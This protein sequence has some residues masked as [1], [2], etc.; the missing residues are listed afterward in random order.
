[1]S[2]DSVPA[3]TRHDLWAE[4][5]HFTGE[6][7]PF[8]DRFP[9]LPA[10]ELRALADD[11]K[12]NGLR[13]PLLLTPDGALVD[14]RNR[15]AACAMA[16]VTP[17]FE[18]TEADPYVVIVSAN[19]E[20]RHLKRYQ[21]AMARALALADQGK[22]RN[23]RWEYGTNAEESSGFVRE[24]QRCGVVIDYRPDLAQAILSDDKQ[25][26]DDAYQKAKTAKTRTE[27]LAEHDPDLLARVGDDLDLDTAWKQYQAAKARAEE[28]REAKERTYREYRESIHLTASVVE[29]L[30]HDDNWSEFIAHYQPG[31]FVTLTSER[32]RRI[33]ELA[34]EFADRWD[35]Q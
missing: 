34:N 2:A 6:I 31:T 29:M 3:M 1:M 15:L 30:R 26:L 4:Q 13:Q 16:G 35:N 28:D 23:G 8:A 5:P 7:H 27:E 20:R 11:I 22:R 25:T 12:A 21:Q 32:W 33:A 24:M 17:R 14:G 10:D 9:M 19:V 18:T